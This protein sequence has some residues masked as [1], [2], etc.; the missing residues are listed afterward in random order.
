MS[1]AFAQCPAHSGSS[2]EDSCDYTEVGRAMRAPPSKKSVPAL[3]LGTGDTLLYLTWQMGMKVTGGMKVANQLI[4]KYGDCSGLF[5][6]PMSSLYS[7][8]ALT[9]KKGPE[10]EVRAMRRI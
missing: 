2:T 3:I 9:W 7:Q 6:G 1:K 5:G 10:K 8:G 4:L